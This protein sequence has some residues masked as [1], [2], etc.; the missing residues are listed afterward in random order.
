MGAKVDYPVN[1]RGRTVRVAVGAHTKFKGPVNLLVSTP[2]KV[3][4]PFWLFTLVVGS[5]EIPISCA[6]MR[7][8][9]NALSVTVGMHCETSGI[10]V[11]GEEIR[12]AT[13]ATG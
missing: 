7:P 10:K 4:S 12:Y 8:W 3:S 13:L 2:P 9:A 5:K 1:S 6:S 11:P